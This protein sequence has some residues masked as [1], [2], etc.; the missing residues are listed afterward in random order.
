MGAAL[1]VRGLLEE[2]AASVSGQEGGHF[3]VMVAAL[4]RFVENEGEGSLPLEVHP[5]TRTHLI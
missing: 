3:W 5:L 4:K 1:E 2:S